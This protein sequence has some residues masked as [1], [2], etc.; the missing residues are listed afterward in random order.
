MQFHTRT[1]PSI[2][3][4]HQ[5]SALANHLRPSVRLA[6][7]HTCDLPCNRIVW[8]QLVELGLGV[9]GQACNLLTFMNQLPCQTILLAPLPLAPS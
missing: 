3:V 9:Q 7:A 5:A 6:Q 1:C 8:L 2:P 4:V